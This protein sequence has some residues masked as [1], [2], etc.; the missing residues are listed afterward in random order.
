[1][2]KA[3]GAVRTEVGSEPGCGPRAVL[4]ILE[5]LRIL[6]SD[7]P[8]IQVPGKAQLPGGVRIF[9]DIQPGQRALLSSAQGPE[10]WSVLPTSSKS[11]TMSCVVCKAAGAPGSTW[12]GHS[13]VVLS[14]GQSLRNSCSG[15]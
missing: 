5:H 3:P 11:P 13:P 7:Q 8:S 9:T 4:P 15:A 1:M 6:Y 12:N 2:S 10:F 14:E